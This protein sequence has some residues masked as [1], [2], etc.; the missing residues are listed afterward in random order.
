MLRAGITVSAL[1]IASA[2]AALGVAPGAVEVRDEAGGV[3]ATFAGPDAEHG[4]NCKQQQFVRESHAAKK[5]RRNRVRGY[6]R[7][8]IPRIADR[9][10]ER[11]IQK[12]L[13]LGEIGYKLTGANYH[14]LSPL[15][16]HVIAV[17]EAYSRVGALEL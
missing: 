14:C 11:A 10:L 1:L 2:P 3:V 6:S 7:R 17:D 8:P 12:F 16:V 9:R 15:R 13:S 4:I 5:V